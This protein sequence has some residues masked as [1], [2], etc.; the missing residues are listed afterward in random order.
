MR[1][2]RIAVIAGGLALIAPRL[3]AQSTMLLGV[4]AG[5]SYSTMSSSLDGGKPGYRST[6]NGGV[7]IGMTLNEKFAIEGQAL[8]VT[9]GFVADTTTGVNVSLSL[10]YI[11]LP[12]M[13]A[14]TPIG[15]VGMVTPRIMVG[16]SLGFRVGCSFVAA[17]AG[18]P[19]VDCD[20]QNVTDFDLAVMGGLGV[21]VGKGQGGLTVDLRFDYGFV[22][23]AKGSESFKNRAWLLSV[24]YL[25]AI[26]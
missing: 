16:P 24:G 8:Y 3:P 14:W 9:K 18:S 2:I 13:F 26:L 11:E 20:P 6:F 23:V 4:T 21:K 7:T 15:R 17:G 25:F 10:D 1:L 5:G 12:L 19:L 22:N